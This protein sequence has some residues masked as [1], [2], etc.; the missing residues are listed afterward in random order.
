[1]SYHLHFT[2][3]AQQD[4][5]FHKKSGNKTLLK[6]MLLLLKEISE[7]PFIGEGKPKPLVH[8]LVGMWSRRINQEHRIVYEVLNDIVV[9]HSTKGHYFQK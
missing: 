5:N 8:E 1:M 2:R 7:H 9:I 3:R 4:I 6:K